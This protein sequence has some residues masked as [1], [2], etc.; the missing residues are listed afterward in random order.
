MRIIASDL[1]NGFG[2]RIH[3]EVISASLDPPSWIEGK[4]SETFGLRWVV[5]LL[6]DDGL[7][8]PDVQSMKISNI[9][10]RVHARGPINME[11]LMEPNT[12]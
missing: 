9:I 4:R 11:K 2:H 12:S 8:S 5:N 6:L 7:V 10:P 3:G 1:L